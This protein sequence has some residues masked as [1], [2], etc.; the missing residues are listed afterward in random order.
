MPALCQDGRGEKTAGVNKHEKF[1]KNPKP[2]FW[3]W[4]KSAT[5]KVGAPSCGPRPHARPT[6]P[7]PHTRHPPVACQP[8]S[9]DPRERSSGSASERRSASCVLKQAREIGCEGFRPF[10]T[11]RKCGGWRGRADV[12]QGV[13]K[14]WRQIR[15]CP[16]R[17]RCDPSAQMAPRTCQHPAESGTVARMR[18]Q[19]YA[20]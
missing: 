14:D 11:C 6:S 8:S 20:R 4:G 5:L 13:R 9:A 15:P 2:G 1:C 10:A 17:H 16:A 12:S 3:V 19:T 18:G 7:C